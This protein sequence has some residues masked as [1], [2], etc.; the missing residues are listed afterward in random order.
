MRFPRWEPER[1]WESLPRGSFLRGGQNLSFDPRDQL[2][3]IGQQTCANLG[4]PVLDRWDRRETGVR[5]HSANPG[6]QRYTILC[7]IEFRV[8]NGRRATLGSP[9]N[10]GDKRQPSVHP[11]PRHQYV[12]CFT[13]LPG[14]IPDSFTCAELT[15]KSLPCRGTLNLSIRFTCC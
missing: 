4:S 13:G 15:R 6:L 14:A 7:P 11:S 3:S 1:R 12:G 9:G 10:A 8:M 5:S 2:V